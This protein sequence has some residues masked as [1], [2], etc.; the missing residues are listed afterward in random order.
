VTISKVK[1]EL[2]PKPR[3]FAAVE[4]SMFV[5]PWPEST[6]SALLPRSSRFAGDYR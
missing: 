1:V 4:F 5:S 6:P 2:L 3:R